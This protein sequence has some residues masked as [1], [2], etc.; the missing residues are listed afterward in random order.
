MAAAASDP[1][2]W[3]LGDGEMARLI[4]GFDWTSTALGPAPG[5]PATLRSAV[6][7]MLDLGFPSYVW[8]GPDFLQLYNDAAITINRA[9]HPTMLGRP[10]AI[11]WSDIWDT[12]GAFANDVMS[13]GRAVLSQ[14]LPLT[15]ERD[16][17]SASAW[18]SFSYNPLRDE[19]GRVAGIFITATE[20][21]ARVMGERQPARAAARLRHGEERYRTIFTS[22]GEPIALC[23]ALS[24]ASGRTVDYRIVEANPAFDRME[25]DVAAVVTGRRASGPS[26]VADAEM[27]EAVRRALAGRTVKIDRVLLDPERWFETQIVPA[28]ESG[29]QRFII[30]ASEITARRRAELALRRSQERQAFL[31][32]L[33]D[34]MRLL[35]DPLQIQS[36]ASRMLGEHLGASRVAYGDVVGEEL[37]IE[38]DYANGVRSGAGVRS[39]AELGQ[40]EIALWRS[41]HAVAVADVARAP[42]L[43]AA[44]RGA[45]AQMDVAAFIVAPLLRD[46]QL[47]GALSVHAAEPRA[48][49]S[50]EIVLVEDVA[51]RIWMAL[52]RMRAEQALQESEERLRIALEAGRMGTWRYDMRTGRQQWSRRQFEIFGLEPTDEAPS[53]ALFLSRVVPED[54]P[55]V[56]FTSDD[57]RPEGTFLD[58]EF[59]IVW[60]NGERRHLIAHALARFDE[61][62]RPYE[63]IGINQDITE[64]K[65]A[66]QA[67]RDSEA[68]L[69]GF[70]EA[71]SDVLW[72]RG[73]EDMQ[74]QFLSPAFETV[75]GLTR[76][77]VEDGDNLESW[78]S[79]VLP[80][81][82]EA[83]LASL[84]KARAGENYIFEYRI[85]HGSDE[86][87]WM[88]STTF[89]M[90]DA[91]G[92]V[93]RIGGIGHD[94]TELK[95]AEEHQRLLAAELQHR[96]RN[97]LAVIRAIARRTART[98]TSVDDYASHIEGRIDAFARVQAAVTRDPIGGVD[99]ATLVAEELRAYRS[100]EGDTL[101]VKGP[102][103]RLRPK[104]AETVGLAIHELATNA[105]KYGALSVP[106]GRLA[107]DWHVI[108]GDA[109][110]LVFVWRETGV[111]DMP[112]RPVRRGFGT[113]VLLQMLA[114]ELGATTTLDFLPSGIACHILLP[115]DGAV[116]DQG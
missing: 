111:P 56:E 66:E 88:R 50:D 49:S 53:R 105:V 36:V 72:V 13:Q 15:I 78:V 104:P 8:W 18:F 115:L 7:M 102:T 27:L 60:P 41:G 26:G 87:R 30:V 35:T 14:D 106:S 57:V 68:L 4:R 42:E 96:V 32:A 70:A 91:E 55:A 67:L 81:D 71:S 34:A 92:R 12:I 48:W 25:G 90:R 54:L 24:D 21:T 10:G 116:L 31:L 84:E 23:E 86:V 109:P 85:R 98:A 39:L 89:P 73:A 99:L 62:G 65:N 75:Y 1:T 107:I 38:M 2:A 5:W 103:V 76:E 101:V 43:S 3:P 9:R 74:W 83:A 40:A 110:K 97:T 29:Q 79:L 63:I 69:R 11:A 16:G 46:G 93:E 37:R 52:E 64:Q 19:V 112:A 58:T 114:Y 82:R 94:L 28:P 22:S 33:S 45:Y 61:N 59:R 17:P 20:T 77:E 80:E 95:R 51:E 47:V 108:E 6:G 113:E 44:E 100:K